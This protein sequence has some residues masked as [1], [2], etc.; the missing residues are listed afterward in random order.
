MADK[1]VRIA[2]VTGA[3][4]GI[5]FEVCRQ[6]AERGF[7]VVLTARDA[8]K[9]RAAAAKLKI[10]GHVEPAVL[11]VFDAQSIGRAAALEAARK[12]YH[13]QNLTTLN[14]VVTDPEFRSARKTLIHLRGKPLS[15]WSTEERHLAERACG[16]WNF[17]AGEEKSFT[18]DEVKSVRQVSSRKGTLIG[19][20]ILAGMGVVILGLVLTRL[21]NEGAI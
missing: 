19:V 20:G 4:R 1:R 8:D 12:A 5:G 18:L 21:H 3:N 10:V 16:L 2:L 9:A 7:T 17:A 13:A 11:D 15:S 6:L 14:E